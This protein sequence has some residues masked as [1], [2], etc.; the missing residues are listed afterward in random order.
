MDVIV[1]PQ[2]HRTAKAGPG[3]IC[4]HTEDLQNA[5]KISVVVEVN[6]QRALALVIAQVDPGAEALVQPLLECGHMGFHI[7]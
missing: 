7:E 1:R 3:S 4:L 6:L 5:L 2:Q